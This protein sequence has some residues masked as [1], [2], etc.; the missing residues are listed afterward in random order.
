[1]ASAYSRNRA[2][3]GIA[4]PVAKTR[5]CPFSPNT[6]ASGSHLRREH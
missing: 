1:V 4:A 6:G 5:L 2:S 3:D